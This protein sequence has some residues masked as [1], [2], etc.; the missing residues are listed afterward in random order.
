MCGNEGDPQW[1]AVKEVFPWNVIKPLFVRS[2][3]SLSALASLPHSLSRRGLC[4]QLIDVVYNVLFGLATLILAAYFS[5][6][7]FVVIWVVIIFGS[8]WCAAANVAL[9]EPE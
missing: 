8:P 3:A 5:E 4:S 6:G 7:W 1:V 9:L 2:A